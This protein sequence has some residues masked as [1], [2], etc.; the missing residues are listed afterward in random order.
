ML[1]LNHD[2]DGLI[3]I[4]LLKHITSNHYSINTPFF[5]LTRNKK[6]RNERAKINNIPKMIHFTQLKERKNVILSDNKISYPQF[7]HSHIRNL[8]CVRHQHV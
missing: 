5:S 1:N 4:S 7:C 2:V 6:F 8:F 3:L